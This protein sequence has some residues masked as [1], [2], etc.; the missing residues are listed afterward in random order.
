MKTHFSHGN[1]EGFS[2]AELER[3]NSIV[4][5]LDIDGEADGDLYKFHCERA[6]ET[7]ESARHG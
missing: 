6:L 4:D 3:A 7:V 1:T 2:D 5:A